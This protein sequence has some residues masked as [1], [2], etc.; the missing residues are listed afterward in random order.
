M[1]EA[2]AQKMENLVGV[3]VLAVSFN[4]PASNRGVIHLSNLVN[5]RNAKSWP[6]LV[7]VHYFRCGVSTARATGQEY[8]ITR[9]FAR[10]F[11]D[12]RDHRVQ[13]A[14]R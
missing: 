12:E 14:L 10:G 6:T 5:W 8:E 13:H 9:S 1:V 7:V 3:K 4:E 2:G 11:K